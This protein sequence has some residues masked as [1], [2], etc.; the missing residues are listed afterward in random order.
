[1][2]E[3]PG[4]IRIKCKKNKV[5]NREGLDESPIRMV[6]RKLMEGASPFK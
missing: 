1:M 3:N 6:H 4:R 2:R 5:G